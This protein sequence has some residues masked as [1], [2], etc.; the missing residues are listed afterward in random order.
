MTQATAIDPQD[1][2]LRATA[3]AEELHLS[4]GALAQMRFRGT[5]PKF[6]KSGTRVLYRRSDIRAWLDANTVQSTADVKTRD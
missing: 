3:T 5:G 2:L 1:E 4:E 6:I